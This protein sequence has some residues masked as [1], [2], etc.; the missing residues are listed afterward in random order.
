MVTGAGKA[1]HAPSA[2]IAIT[3]VD[4]VSEKSLLRVFQ[5]QRKERLTVDAVL[6]VANDCVFVRIAE[7]SEGSAFLG[8]AILVERRQR[9]AA[10]ALLDRLRLAG[11][12]PSFP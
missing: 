3:V 9:L 4:R 8:L 6:E 10:T 11:L 1:D 7:R 2:H 12:A 5:E